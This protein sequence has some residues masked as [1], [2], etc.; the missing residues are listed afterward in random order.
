MVMEPDTI[1]CVM[2][3]AAKK[4]GKRM[5]MSASQMEMIAENKQKA[6]MLY[7][8]YVEKINAFKD[9][10]WTYG[11]AIMF[12]PLVVDNHYTTIVRGDPIC[13]YRFGYKEE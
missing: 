10:G 5:Q 9:Q 2:L 13:E 4:E 1:Y 7:T 12:T 3:G 11:Q 6:L 8:S